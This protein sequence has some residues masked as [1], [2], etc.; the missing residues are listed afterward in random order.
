MFCSTVFYT[1]RSI[2]ETFPIIVDSGFMNEYGSE[3]PQDKKNQQKNSGPQFPFGGG[4]GPKLPDFKPFGKWKFSIIYIVI[5]IIGLSLFNYVFLN[6]VNPTIDFSEFKARIA[7]GEIKRVELTDSYFTGY[8]SAQKRD[9]SPS[10][11]FRGSAMSVSETVYR[12]VP[13]NDPDIIKLMDEK[14]VA[15]YAVSRFRAKEALY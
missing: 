4:G 13:L 10:P 14:N 12:T 8:T 3:D 7:S 2:V 15:Y 9:S 1:G 6:K 11:M 5:L